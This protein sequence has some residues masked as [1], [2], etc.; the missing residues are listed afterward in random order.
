MVKVKQTTILIYLLAIQKLSQKKVNIKNNELAT[1]LNV[2]PS[3]V[4]EMLNK[5]ITEGFVS[6]EQIKL[7]SKGNKFIAELKKR[8]I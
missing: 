3:S 8:I 6:S 2:T 1:I 5:L 7:T 4:S